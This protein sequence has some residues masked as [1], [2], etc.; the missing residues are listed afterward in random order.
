M[1]S[2]DSHK[3]QDEEIEAALLDADLF[4]KYQAPQKAI[5]KLLAAIATHPRAPNLREKLR[6]IAAAS[7]QHGE[8]ARQCLALAN[9][10]IAREDFEAA[11][12]RLLEA[13]Q[14]DPRIS[15]TSG[16]DAI[17]RA[18]RPD[19]AAPSAPS[20]S[21]SSSPTPR[22]RVTLAGDLATISIFDA[23][24]VLENSRLTGALNVTSDDERQG[25]VHFN[26]GRI[27]GAECGEKTALDAFRSVVE[28][29]AGEFE[30]EKS[31]QGFPV[32]I[33]ALSNTNL[34]LDTLRQLD[35]EK[36]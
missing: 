31:E 26:E 27:V 17:R 28:I 6:E 25:Q 1:G 32:T 12:E 30:F 35:E 3:S 15:I 4:L 14:F 7:K 10:Y 34:I 19:L 24:Q 11:H 23:V 21:D 2:A 20:A 5:G 16:L 36:M 33:E 29:T 8:A 9:L 18:R 22:R 13:K